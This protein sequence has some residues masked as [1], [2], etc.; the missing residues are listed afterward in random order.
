MTATAQR[1]NRRRKLKAP[2]PYPGG[3]S[4]VAPLVWTRLG[5]V[6]NLIIP[7]AGTLSELWACPSKQLP[8][9]V[10]VN[11]ADC[12]LAN[13]WRAMQA[14]PAGV[15]EYADWPVSE[16][17]LHAR[18]RW[19]CDAGWPEPVAVPAEFD[20]HPLTRAAY[21]A[22]WRRTVPSYAASFRDRMRRDPAYYDARVAGWW[23]WGLSCWIGGG[24]CG[25]WGAAAEGTDRKEQRPNC[26]A[27]KGVTALSLSDVPTGRPQLGDAYDIGRGVNA[28][29]VADCD[30]R[31]RLAARNRAGTG[32]HGAC[33]DVE[34][35]VP[36]LDGVGSGGV[37]GVNGVNG[38]EGVTAR[39]RAGLIA[40]FTELQDRLR[41]VRVCCGDWA[42]VCSSETTTT[43]LG[44]TGV[45][46]DPPYAHSIERMQAWV[47]HLD[48][49]ESGNADAI[50]ANPPPPASKT[51]S[52]DADLYAM[53][54][55]QDTDRMV[56]E[57]HRWCREY[58]RNP[59]IRIALCGYAGE[60][61]G[62][63]ALGWSAIAWK[64]Q[65]G[66]GNRKVKR[67]EANVN[68]GRERIWFSPACV[69]AKQGE[70]F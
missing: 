40:W 16:A 34:H 5:T 44:L 29:G 24:W 19:L 17:D 8:S 67:G 62:L 58:G 69:A 20:R 25:T 56:A 35:W 18:H 57:V 61:D 1:V 11:D 28:G 47:A 31:P 13:V 7:F 51:S 33:V 10:T 22:G 15:A 14:D 21:L 26:D 36:K 53:D 59:R 2:F 3:K 60:H 4:S 9:I 32:V 30:K 52:R 12:Y 23:I 41:M 38:G 70:L 6:D 55:Q 42:R 50:T 45:I 27:M 63:E 65:G 46:L 49:V 37:N 39:R 68:R 66:Y 48:A 43:R 54:R 64:A